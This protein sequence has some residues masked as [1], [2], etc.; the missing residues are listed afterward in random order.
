MEWP[1]PWPFPFAIPVPVA[2]SVAV[3]VA[4]AV[5]VSIPEVKPATHGRHFCGQGLEKNSGLQ[6]PVGLGDDR[7]RFEHH[8]EAR[9]SG[10]AAQ[11]FADAGAQRDLGH[12]RQV[13]G[14]FGRSDRAQGPVSHLHQHDDGDRD[15]EP[16]EGT[17]EYLGGTVTGH[18]GD[19][20]LPA[21][22]QRGS[23]SRRL[24]HDESCLR[25]PVLRQLRPAL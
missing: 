12:D 1:F 13:E 3:A 22:D 25:R 9:C 24:K 17:A 14:R 20:R 8:V 21:D 16:A 23:A 19:G 15:E 6:Q 7:R 10:A 2:V 11:R 5:A 18:R 4:V